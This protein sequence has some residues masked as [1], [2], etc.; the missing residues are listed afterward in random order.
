MTVYYLLQFMLCVLRFI[1]PVYL[2]ELI[3][4]NLLVLKIRELLS[5]THFLR[6]QRPQLRSSTR[7]FTPVENF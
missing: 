7:R 1:V 5:S 6:L 4:K 3:L 2:K